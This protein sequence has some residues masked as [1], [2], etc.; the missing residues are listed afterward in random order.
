MSGIFSRIRSIF[1][2]RAND[3]L[4]SMEDPRK[5]L[6]YSLRKLEDNRRELI[7][8]LVEVI[9]TRKGLEGQL[10]ITEDRRSMLQEQAA[11]AMS[12]GDE[13][14]TRFTLE[15]K[16]EVD[17]RYR[18]LENHLASLDGQ[19]NTLKESL[20]ALERKVT[21][22]RY[23]KEELKSIYDSA[24]AQLRIRESLSGVSTDINDVGNT[25]RRI[26]DRINTMRARTEAINSL[27]SEGVISDA[28]EESEL[29]HQISSLKRNQIIE[30][31]L[32][33]LKAGTAAS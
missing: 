17:D 25:I 33:Q 14:L 21:L 29:E 20:A 5:T 12:S 26:E 15:R 18:E 7:R 8:T 19:I 28:L 4:D 6:D 11:A 16:Q 22:F 2:S 32:K 1:Q 23:K 30:E 3:A 24:R 9:T 10:K 13:N 31:E 27:I